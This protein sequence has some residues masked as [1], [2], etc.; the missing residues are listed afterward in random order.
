MDR[1]LC[2]ALNTKQSEQTTEQY[3]MKHK[4]KKKLNCL[5]RCVHVCYIISPERR[6]KESNIIF[7]RSYKYNTNDTISGCIITESLLLLNHNIFCELTTVCICSSSSELSAAVV[8]P[9]SPHR[10]LS[11]AP[12]A[13]A[14]STPGT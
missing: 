9:G 10:I 6:K 12:S 4:F 7:K 2:T 5:A 3:C 14:P 8:R 13:S 11:S 1:R